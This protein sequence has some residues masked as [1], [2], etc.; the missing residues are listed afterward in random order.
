MQDEHRWL[1]DGD[2][3]RAVYVRDMPIHIIEEH[4]RDGLQIL[5][6]P[7]NVADPLYWC[8]LRLEVELV[9]RALGI[10]IRGFENE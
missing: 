1:P 7:Y 4:L 2:E 5:N 9:R 3:S 10:P 8:R 6:N